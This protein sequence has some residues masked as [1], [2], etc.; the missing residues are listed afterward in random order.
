M[1]RAAIGT[2]VRR[3]HGWNPGRNGA[4]RNL[5]W[6][7]SELPRGRWQARAP[8][9][10]DRRRSGR[11]DGDPVRRRARAPL[12]L[13]IPVIDMEGTTPRGQ[14]R[15][16]ARFGLTT[17]DAHQLSEFYERALD[18]RLL[19]IERRSGPDFERLMGV[20]GGVSAIILGLGDEVVE[21]LQFDRPGRLY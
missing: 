9:R 20:E 16:L 6:R 18:F 19:R 10:H 3:S 5:V 11:A 13:R 8:V 12:T 17:P 15:R 14:I 4:G 21:L 7:R 1:D 2:L